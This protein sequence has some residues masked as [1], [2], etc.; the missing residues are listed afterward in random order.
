MKHSNAVSSSYLFLKASISAQ[1]AMSGITPFSLR[2]TC[3]H[4]TLLCHSSSTFTLILDIIMILADMMLILRLFNICGERLC[5]KDISNMGHLR[6]ILD[7]L[8]FLNYVRC[9][10]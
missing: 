7:N 10:A 8:R 5:R 4:S 1:M 6:Q 9:S 3:H 2:D